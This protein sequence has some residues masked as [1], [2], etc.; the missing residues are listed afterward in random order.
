MT[1][2]DTGSPVQPIFPA[3]ADIEQ[4]RAL[5][6]AGR[7]KPMLGGRPLIAY[8]IGIAAAS[9]LQFA[10]FACILPLPPWSVAVMWAFIMLAAG[11]LGRARV[12]DRAITHA[13]QVEREVWR[14]GGTVLALG[15]ASILALGLIY[16]SR[17]GD[18]VWAGFSP[19]RR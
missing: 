10:I 6:E 17:S 8:G 7:N 3:S 16:Q 14:A 12:A 11:V 9:A 5:A 2:P 1:E 13:N 18:S 15:A 4:L 19:Y